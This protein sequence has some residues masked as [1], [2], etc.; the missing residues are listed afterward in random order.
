MF[1]IRFISSLIEGDGDSGGPL[2]DINRKVVVGIA[3][4]VNGAGC[5]KG[6]PDI[7]TKVAAFFDW[8][9]N[10]TIITNSGLTPMLG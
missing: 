7:F 5:G 2:V 3:E 6:K 9:K 4:A 8:I 10:N 1:R